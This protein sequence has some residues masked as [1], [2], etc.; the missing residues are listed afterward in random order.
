MMDAPGFT[1]V[2]LKF[3]VR[4]SGTKSVFKTKIKVIFREEESVFTRLLGSFAIQKPQRSL[5]CD[6]CNLLD[7]LIFFST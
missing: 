4:F 3:P 5:N 7:F 1:P 2:Q 6:C